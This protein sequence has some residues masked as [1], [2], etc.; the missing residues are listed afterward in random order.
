MPSKQDLETATKQAIDGGEWTIE[1]R[2][3]YASLEFMSRHKGPLMGMTI[4]R[5]QAAYFDEG[6]KME[7]NFDYSFFE[8]DLKAL[9]GMTKA[10]DRAEW[11]RMYYGSTPETCSKLLKSLGFTEETM[12][13]L[14][15]L[16]AKYTF[17]G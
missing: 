9:V 3:D 2:E 14:D 1:A 6:Q 10:E 4:A 5:P 17:Q 15:E 7:A 8:G 16:A 13:S 11:R 12:P